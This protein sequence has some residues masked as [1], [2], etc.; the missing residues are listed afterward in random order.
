MAARIAQ[1]S[2]TSVNADSRAA[3]SST[4]SGSPSV[5]A[6]SG[7]RGARR[8][9]R[10]A[11]PRSPRPASSTRTPSRS[12]SRPSR[13]RVQRDQR[14]GPGRR[15]CAGVPGRR[16][17]RAPPRRGATG[18]P[19]PRSAT[20]RARVAGLAFAV[21]A[22]AISVRERSRSVPSAVSRSTRAATSRSA[23]AIRSSAHRDRRLGPR[24]RVLGVSPRAVVLRQLRGE[25]VAAAH[26]SSSARVSHVSSAVASSSG[27]RSSTPVRAARRAGRP[28]GARPRCPVARAGRCASW[29]LGWRSRSRGLWRAPPPRS[30]GGPRRACTTRPGRVEGSSAPLSD[31]VR[32]H[33]PV[34]GGR[35]FALDALEV[36]RQ[37]AVFGPPLERSVRRTE[38][39]AV[40]STTA[41]PSR[42]T[43]V[44]PGGIAAWT[45]RH[46]PRSGNQTVRS[47]RRRTPPVASRRTALGQPAAARGATASSQRRVAASWRRSRSGDPFLDHQPPTFCRQISDRVD[48]TRYARARSASAASTA[49]R[50]SGSTTRSSSRRR[51][52]AFRAARAMGRRSSSSSWPRSASTRPRSAAAAV[53]AAARRSAA[54]A[55]SASAA[56]SASPRRLDGCLARTAP[57]RSRTRALDA[58][59]RIA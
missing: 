8:I 7:E 32:P 41:E 37:T 47:S 19:R 58:R 34:Y 43:A 45:S 4:A 31:A 15:P 20:P 2:A 53:D 48:G 5:A 18:P 29:P 11:N 49:A 44:Q 52:P 27:C 26:G 30:A 59:P 9:P 25:A 1:R 24:P 16:S 36:R 54:A 3:A 55:R 10:L 46:A 23:R 42:G 38:G 50:S 6:S 28:A 56:S 21:L 13:P 33:R 57:R 51:P 40:S 35:E 22:T 12:D 14:H 39:H 17:R